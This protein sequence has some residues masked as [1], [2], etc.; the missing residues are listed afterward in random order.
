MDNL[1]QIGIITLPMGKAGLLHLYNFINVIEPSSALIYVITSVTKSNPL[2]KNLFNNEKIHFHIVGYRLS[3]HLL[4]N[5]INYIIRQIEISIEMIKLS[6][7]IDVWIFFLDSHILFIPVLCA[8]LLNKRVVFSLGASIEGTSIAKGDL[9]TRISLL[10]LPINYFLCDRIVLYS[11][12]LIDTWDLSKYSNKIRI[13][14]RHF[15]DHTK[16]YD[17]ANYNNRKNMIGFVGRLSEEKGILN[18]VK[19]IS[20]ILES[21]NSRYIYIAGEGHLKPKIY[22]LLKE[23]GKNIILSKWVP[24]DQLGNILNN[25]KLLVLP[26]YSE[27]LPN[28]ILES[29]ACGTPVLATSVGAIPDIIKDEVTGFIIDINNSDSITKHINRALRFPDIDI[30]ILN[31]KR[32]IFDEFSLRNAIKRWKYILDEL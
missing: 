21:D 27:G 23:N 6:K 3:I 22:N 19:S 10:F 2:N 13:A 18:F 14:S 17:Q 12:R 28:I 4:A 24:H 20:N 30:L 32:L 11:E 16:F 15:V 31:A 26:S 5:A 8:K 25:L 1:K 9:F 7:R 29:M